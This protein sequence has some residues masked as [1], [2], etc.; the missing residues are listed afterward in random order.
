MT[1]AL[2]VID[3]QQEYGPG[4]GLAIPGIEATS[5][6][7]QRLIKGA[8][9]AKLPVVFVRHVS[10]KYDDSTFNAGTPSVC[11]LQ[12]LE[13]AADDIVVTKQYPG[14]FTETALDRILRDHGVRQVV[15]CGYTSFLCCDSTARQAFELGYD[16]LY[17]EDAINEFPL[18]GLDQATVH[19]VVSAVQGV[20]FSE[21]LTTGAAVERLGA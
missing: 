3:P 13:P 11:F 8:R 4:G 16:V 5:A 2:V 20:M 21:V 19:S 18:D 6:N 1:Q 15:I 10:R 9:V 17:V 14:A 12:D 7:I